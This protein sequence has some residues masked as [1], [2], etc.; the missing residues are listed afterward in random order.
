MDVW[1]FEEWSTLVVTLFQGERVP[2]SEWVRIAEMY[3]RGEALHFWTLR[4]ANNS[5]A[6]DWYYFTASLAEQF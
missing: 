5:E 3:L 1:I 4:K 2:Q 6:N